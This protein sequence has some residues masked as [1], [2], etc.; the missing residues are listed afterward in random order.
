MILEKLEIIICLFAG[1]AVTIVGI[2]A[3]R[4]LH[5]VLLDLFIT[6][7]VFYVI[8]LFVKGYINKKIFP[9]HVEPK[10]GEKGLGED[11]EEG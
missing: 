9:K 5:V 8:G 7:V 6:L 11:G 10:D 4:E 1:L 2:A 3:R